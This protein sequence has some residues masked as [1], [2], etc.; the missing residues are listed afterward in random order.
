LE[1]AD[2]SAA[3]EA[4]SNST[5]SSGSLIPTCGTLYSTHSYERLHLF[6]YFFVELFWHFNSCMDKINV[7][8]AK[9]IKSHEN[10]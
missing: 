9:T 7:P 2:C 4:D 8:L 10:L 1:G 3:T 5:T 6:W